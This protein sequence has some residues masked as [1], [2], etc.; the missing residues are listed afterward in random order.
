[1]RTLIRVLSLSAALLLAAAMIWS[2]AGPVLLVAALGLPVLSFGYLVMLAGGGDPTHWQLRYHLPCEAGQEDPSELDPSGRS[3]DR[4]EQ[5]LQFLADRTGHFVLEATARGLFLELS[6][7]YDRYIEAQLPRALAEVKLSQPEDNREGPSAGSFFLCTGSPNSDLLRWATEDRGRH[8]RLH[9]HHGPHTTLIAET[10]GTRPP[11]RWIRLPL[12]RLLRRLWYHLP[13]W[14]DLSFGTQV[15]G[16]LPRTDA[17]TVYSSRSRLHSL[18]PPDEYTPAQVGRPLGES[19]DARPLTLSYEVP[20]FTIGAPSAF[21]AQQALADLG[22]GWPVVVVSPHRSVLDRIAHEA[23]ETS[24]HWLDPQYTHRSAHLALMSAAEWKTQNDLSEQSILKATETFLADLGVD[25][26]LP[27]VGAFCRSLIRT[28]ASSA[29]HRGQDFAFTDLYDVS[30]STRTLR[31]FLREGHSLRNPDAQELLAQLDDEGGYVQA[32]TIL[33]AIRTALAPLEAGPLHALCQP[34]FLNVSRLLRER[35]LLLVPMTDTDFPQHDRLLSAML[36]LTLNRIL[37]SQPHPTISVHLHDP[38]LYRNDHGRRWIDLAR[39][40][41]HLSLMLD[42]Q[43]ADRYRPG[44]GSQVIFRC[45][46]TLA[47]RLIEDWHLP[48]S[49]SDLTE[50]P[51]DTAVARLPGMVVALKVRYP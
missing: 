8:M 15:S 42:I 23:G 27:A 43:Q 47:S 31:A 20:L 16:L 46:D 2:A 40:N 34:P 37:A 51:A 29:R 26:A 5:V 22:A 13:L 18:I 41:P 32:V 24:I 7:A 17:D 48:A 33:S 25:V 4:L 21:L 30:R 28:L 38:H 12:A 3:L 19:T 44:E 49:L 10:D 35:G 39:R 11:G 1:M 50:L 45:S 14:D 9:I 6:P 36:D